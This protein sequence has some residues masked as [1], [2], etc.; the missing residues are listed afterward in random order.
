MRKTIQIVLL[1]AAIFAVDRRFPLHAQEAFPKTLIISERVGEE[2]DRR[3]RDEYGLFPAVK[4]F[5]SAKVVQTRPDSLVL[6]LVVA[7]D[8]RQ[9]LQEIPLTLGSLSNLAGQIEFLHKKTKDELMLEV[10]NPRFRVSQQIVGHLGAWVGGL[11]VVALS[12]DLD[13]T[14]KS[15]SSLYL[16]WGLGSAFFSSL[17]I[18]TSGKF[19]RD[20]GLFLPSFLGSVIGSGLGILFFEGSIQIESAG[21]AVLGIFFIQPL[22]TASGGIRGYNWAVKNR[23]SKSRLGLLNLDQKGL[24]FDIPSIRVGTVPDAG[25][26]V[27]VERTYELKILNLSF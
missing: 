20:A 27:Q 24:G 26:F 9:T 22:L 8:G 13:L 14:P 23:I 16:T 19:G 7:E 4:G 5:V 17:A 3:E 12:R 11:F 18:H 15:K 6:Q 10:D 2:I 21:L 25:R 1:L